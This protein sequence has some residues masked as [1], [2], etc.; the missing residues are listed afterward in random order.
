MERRKLAIFAVAVVFAILLSSTALAIAQEELNIKKEGW[1][2]EIIF[3]AEDDRAKVVDMLSKG[4]LDI[5][6]IDISDPDL[7]RQIRETPDLEYGFSYGLYYELTFNPV[8]PEFPATGELNPFSNPKIREAMNYIIDRNYIVDELMG[9]LGS[10]K[11]VP[12]PKGFP[13]YERY[14]DVIEGIE[15][16]YAYDFDKGKQTIEQ[17][18]ANMGATKQGDKWYYKGNPITIKFLIR[19]EDVRKEIGDYVA[20]QL[21]AIGLTVDRMYKTSKEAAPYWILG[22]PA[23]GEWHM[24]T[25]GWITTV[26]SRDDA[27]NFAFFY[28]DMGFSWSP[29]WQAY[30]PSDEFYNVAKQLAEKRFHSMD[31]RN[32]LMRQA[33]QY[34]IQDSVRVWLTDQTAVWARRKNIDA[35][36]DLAA[37][38]AT[39]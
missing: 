32:Q 37:G 21:E 20:N 30:S 39:P 34:A 7:F 6:F 8:G 12:V 27:D 26:V 16:Q 38:Y 23:D 14:K 5:Y 4:D 19:T 24:Y 36:L 29:L 17:E 10:P 2:D 15:Q 11:F 3:V 13:E 1:L 25:G 35:V 22:D 31:E 18:L 9:G 28:T 33:F